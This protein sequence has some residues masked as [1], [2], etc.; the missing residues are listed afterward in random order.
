MIPSK[1]FN[2]LNSTCVIRFETARYTHAHT[3]WH[4]DMNVQNQ[5]TRNGLLV[6]YTI[7][8]Q[9]SKVWFCGSLF[10]TMFNHWM[11]ILLVKKCLNFEWLKVILPNNYSL[12]FMYHVQSRTQWI[13]F[14]CAALF[15]T[16]MVVAAL[17]KLA[18]YGQYGSLHIWTSKI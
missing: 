5:L 15:R 8:A 12:I 9:K 3:S 6:Q 17:S 18:W 13:S 10:Q 4:V 7:I 16:S 2:R 11:M 14:H 1:L